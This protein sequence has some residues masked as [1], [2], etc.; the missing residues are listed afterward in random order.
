[1]REGYLC[2]GETSTFPISMLAVL[3]KIYRPFSQPSAKLKQ[4]IKGEKNNLPR[5]L[6]KKVTN[7]DEKISFYRK[8]VH[9]RPF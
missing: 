1:V 9:F 2:Q 8:S 7:F 6:W 5:Q 3:G 4:C